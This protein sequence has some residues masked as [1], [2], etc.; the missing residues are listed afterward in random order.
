MENADDA[1]NANERIHNYGTKFCPW[2]ITAGGQEVYLCAIP[3]RNVTPC[4]V[5]LVV[6]EINFQC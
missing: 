5:M 2:V 1:R 3:V 6:N 4:V